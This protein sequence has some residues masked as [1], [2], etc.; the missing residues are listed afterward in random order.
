MATTAPSI[1]PAPGAVD[2][3][4]WTALSFIA[5][6][7]LMVTLDTTIVNIALPHAQSAL[8]ISDGNRQ[9][10]ITA[11][12]LAFGGLLLFGGRLADLLGRKRTFL[13]G[14]IGFAGSSAVGGAAVNAGMLFGA[15]ALQGAFGALLAPSAL[16]MLA[17]M[18]TEPKERAK[19]FGIWGAI[20][21][22]GASA[23]V[24]LGGVLTQYLSWRWSLYVNVLIAIIA[25]TGATIFIDRGLSA[26]SRARLD[27]PGVVLITGGLVLLVYGFSRAESNGWRD[28]ITLG[29][30]GA[31]AVLII[32]FAVTEK[33]VKAPLLPLRVVLNR[34]RGGAYLALGL[35]ISALYGLFLFLTYYLQTVKNYSPVWTGLAFLPM[36]VSFIIGSTQISARLMHRI[37]PRLLLVPVLVVAGAGV[38]LLTQLKTG[39]PYTDLVLPAEIL[40]GFGLGSTLTPTINLA[41]IGVSPKDAGVASAMATT[42]QQVGGSIGTA[43]L[44]TIAATAAATY[45]KDHA[46]GRPT[47]QLLANGE[48]H[49]FTVALWWG[50]GALALAVVLVLVLINA[51]A[52]HGRHAVASDAQ[53]RAD[54]PL[55]T[56]QAPQLAALVSPSGGAG[57]AGAGAGTEIRGYVKGSEGA[58]LPRA[59]LTLI[60]QNGRQLG[61]A[62]ARA[63]GGYAL[64]AP[65]SGSYVLI[66]AADGHQ[67]QAATVV[68]G[69]QPLWYDLVLAGTAGLAGAVRD[70]AGAA[71]VAGAMVVVTDVRGEVVASAMTA[72]DG[73]F[74][75]QELV[76]GLFTLAVNAPGY[77]PAAVLAE[78]GASGTTQ[79]EVELRAGA[80]LLG[81]VRGGGAATPLADARVMLVDATGTV[82]A[83][84]TTEADGGCTFTDLAAG[85]YTVIASGYPPVATSVALDGTGESAFD[86]TLA[87]PEG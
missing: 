75:V 34:N 13:I 86:V 25:F 80:R 17:V 67:P 2:P 26:R 9:W 57:G 21:G 7:Q 64:T 63:D 79:C 35:S 48:V 69:D 55:Q 31:A 65:G 71:P 49:G 50:V 70:A 41:T 58:P 72:E 39:S 15:R 51:R 74:G 22:G 32:A 1:A 83:A 54:A 5:L 12:T 60:D 11:Y 4:R 59:A 56:E 61:R 45:I 27:I 82:V 52:Q 85:D 23:G 8:H 42:S 78:V 18:F 36:T 62:P 19:A 30:F 44:N 43:L 40:L 37:A 14:L 29:A 76:A 53:Q 68:V 47:P 28:H 81:T 46:F 73:T 6:A 33:L 16:S 77:R 84:T 3:R 20:A 10:V 38:G 87:H 66:A 24:I